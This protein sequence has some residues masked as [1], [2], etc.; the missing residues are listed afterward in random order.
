MHSI[1]VI[2]YFLCNEVKMKQFS[3]YGDPMY[4]VLFIGK[5]IHTVAIFL[6]I[7]YGFLIAVCN[8]VVPRPGCFQTMTEGHRDTKAN[9]GLLR[10]PS[11]LKIPLY[12]CPSLFPE[13]TCSLGYS[14]SLL[15]GERPASR[16]D[17]SPEFL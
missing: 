4:P 10:K 13:T 2:D 17:K 9:V 11:G 8:K 1:S 14:F 5:V 15:S 12:P 6:R 7:F 16:C 3:P